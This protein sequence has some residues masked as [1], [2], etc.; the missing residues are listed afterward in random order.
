MRRGYSVRHLAERAHVSYPTITRIERGTMSP[1][2]DMLAKLAR[3]LKVH[4]TELFP[5]KPS[6]R[7]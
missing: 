7:R 2:V 4:I 6:R 5:P 1:T 3:A